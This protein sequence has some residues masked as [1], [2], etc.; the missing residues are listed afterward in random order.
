MIFIPGGTYSI[1]G[2]DHT[3]NTDN[4]RSRSIKAQVCDTGRQGIERKTSDDK[5]EPISLSGPQSG[6][7]RIYHASQNLDFT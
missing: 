2:E 7:A 3:A 6:D 4:P 5:L 1:M